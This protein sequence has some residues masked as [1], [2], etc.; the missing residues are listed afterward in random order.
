MKTLVLSMISIA[1]TVAAMT[2]CTSESDPVDETQ[3]DEKVEIKLNA[4]VMEIT[5][6]AVINKGSKFDAQ[7]VASKTDAEYTTPLWTTA[8]D[9]NIS[10]A[11]D[12]AV[13]FE[14][15]QYYPADGTSIYMKGFAPR[16]T[17]T[18]GKVN[19]TI[20]G[21]EDI[22]ISNQISGDKNNKSSTGKKLTFAH[23]LTQLKIKVIAENKAAIDAW[24]TITSIEVQNPSTSLVLDLKAGTIAESATPNKQNLGL[25]GFTT[26]MTL[27]NKTATPDAE[28]AKDAGYIMLLPNASA[29][30]LFITTS[31][32]TSGQAITTTLSATSASNAYEVTLTFK[33]AKI[34]VTAEADVW[35]TVPGIEGDVE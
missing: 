21:D 33:S 34:D 28:T 11:E 4:G 17:I 8:T 18:D 35:T 19:Y 22:M 29:Y 32:N 31:N 27:P 2:A 12:G 3:N 14:T 9:G 10:I 5:S 6:K 25:K 15:P 30:T 23:L 16:K 26:G 24:G 13:S 1:A 20:T 7:I